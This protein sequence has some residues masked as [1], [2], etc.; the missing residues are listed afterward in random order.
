[1]PRQQGQRLAGRRD[2]QRRLA[3]APDELQRLGDE[4]DLAN[5]AAAQLDVVP[6]DRNRVAA[7]MGGDLAL[8]RMDILDRREVEMP[9]PYERPDAGEELLCGLAIAG[10]RARLDHRR[11]LPVLPDAAVIALR[12]RHRHRQRRD[13]GI[14]PESQI[15]PQHVA[16]GGAFLQHRHQLACQP[17]EGLVNALVVAPADALAVV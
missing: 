11:A 14:G 17:H 5:A 8:D 13:A 10:D 16:I 6:L 3:P 15:G 4:L 1:V 2:A 7:A 9:A 12:D